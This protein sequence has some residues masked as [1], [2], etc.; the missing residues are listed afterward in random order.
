MAQSTRGEPVEL[1]GFRIVARLGEGGMGRVHLARSA[2]GRL[3]A[4]KTVHEHLAVEAEFRERFRRETVAVRAVAGPFTAAVLDADPDAE[5]PWL[6]TEFCAGPDLTAAVAA[7]GPL[8]PAELATL[9]AALAEALS[10]VHAVG[11]THRDLKPSN[12]LIT[13]DGPKVLDFGIAKSAADESL[14]AA[15]EAIGSPG[16]IAPEQLARDGEPGPAADVFALG[17]VLALTATGRAPFGTGGAAAVLYRTLH[18]EP[19]LEGVPGT[20]WPTFLARCLA[21]DPADRPTVG[22]VLAWCGARA[23]DSPWWERGPVPELVL[24]HEDEVAEL[25][26]RDEESTAAVPGPRNAPADAVPGARVRGPRDTPADAR[27]PQAHDQAAVPL[28]SRRRLL[29]WTGAA[30]ATAGVATATAI[31]LNQDDDGGGTGNKPDARR[32]RVPRGRVRWKTGIG[33]VAY[34]GALL[35]EGDD[36]YVVDDAAVTRLDAAKSTLRWEYPAENLRGVDARGDFV[37]VL[38]DPLFEPELIALRHSTGRKAWD[39]GL[40]SR[41]PHRPRRPFDAKPSEQEG[42]EGQFIVAGDVACLLT[43]AAYGTMQARRSAW[44]RPWRAYG[45]DSRTGEP[46]WFHGGGAGEVIGADQAGGRIALAVSANPGTTGT[47]AYAQGDPLVVLRAASGKVEKE[48]EDGARRPQVH[49]GADGTRYYAG[50]EEFRAVDLATGRTRWTRPAGT[51]SHITPTAS[52]GLVH[53]PVADGV[54]AYDATSGAVRWTRDGVRVLEETPLVSD[55]LVYVAGPK[56][57]GSGEPTWGLYALD[58][59]TGRPKWALPLDAVTSVDLATAG[60]GLIHLCADGT[61]Y[62][63]SGPELP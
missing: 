45:F 57:G 18:D 28:P 27:P 10:G 41:N 63:I 48:I 22:E 36:L 31:A 58:A 60:K 40:L 39:S 12:I 20:T 44:G 11:L 2:S 59:T 3:A 38:R 19:D 30:L 23:D 32:T 29:A 35:C 8:G 7:H 16:F 17:A 4:V 52:N 49:P 34:G 50:R 9:G 14:T 24:R 51:G 6:A 5:R 56:P 47:D 61:L 21:R 43:Y 42:N 15:D 46:L 26:T 13:R 53:A 62:T 54:R 25:V 37:Y 33:E 55:G 1:G